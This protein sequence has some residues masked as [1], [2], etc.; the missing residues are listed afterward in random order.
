[1]NDE[2]TQLEADYTAPTRPMP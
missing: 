1:M 2:A